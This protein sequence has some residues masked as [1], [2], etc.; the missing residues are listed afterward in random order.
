MPIVSPTLP[1]QA[2]DRYKIPLAHSKPQGQALGHRFDRYAMP[3]TDATGRQQR[4]GTYCAW[5][6]TESMWIG[7]VRPD[8]VQPLVTNCRST[9]AARPNLGWAA[10]HDDGCS[11]GLNG[12]CCTHLASSASPAQP[13]RSAARRRRQRSLAGLLC[14]TGG[15]RT[16]QCGPIYAWDCRS[17]GSH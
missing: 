12:W 15:R 2:G 5:F 17:A 7:V 11:M 13:T 4:T 14:S 8:S 1:T 9:P 16:C 6:Q 10:G 3:R